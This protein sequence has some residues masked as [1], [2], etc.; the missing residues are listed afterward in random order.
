VHHHD[1]GHFALR[2]RAVR[3]VQN[4]GNLQPIERV[5]AH[6][7]RLDEIGRINLRG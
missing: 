5:V 7:P 3:P 2:R 1:R 6:H 4:R